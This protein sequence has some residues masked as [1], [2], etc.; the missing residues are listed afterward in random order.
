MIRETS[1]KAYH[2]ALASGLIS[3]RRGQCLKIVAEHG[4]ITSNEAF[5]ILK[6]ELGRNFRFDSNT[7][8]RFTELR[9]QDVVYE[10][11]ERECRITGKTVIEWEMTLRRP[12]PY[13]KPE[14]QME[15]LKL[16]IK[17]LKTELTKL[18]AHIR[19]ITGQTDLDLGDV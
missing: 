15:K 7:R 4:P 9:Q 19:K 2:E 16:E 6:D 18:R 13:V 5:N 1:I 17:R 3:K 12:K 14:T 8:A 11:Q 10:R